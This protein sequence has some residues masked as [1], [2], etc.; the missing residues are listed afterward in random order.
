M[1]RSRRSAGGAIDYVPKPWDNGRLVALLRSLLPVPVVR[2]SAPSRSDTGSPAG[3]RSPEEP[4]FASEA[5]RHVLATIE[6]V[7][8]SDVAV[9]VTGEHG[10]G[11]D[12]RAA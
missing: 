6:Q 8:F 4:G 10:T 5:M 9:L 3:A 11:R 7:A 12:R 2:E 1:A